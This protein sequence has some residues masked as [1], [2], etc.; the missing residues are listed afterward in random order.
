MAQ[1]P[2]TSGAGFILGPEPAPLERTGRPIC[3]A[4]SD[5]ILEPAPPVC[6]QGPKPEVCRLGPKP[7]VCR[8]GPKPEVCRQGPKPEVCRLGP[9]PEVY[10][11]PERTPGPISCT[12]TGGGGC[13]PVQNLAGYHTKTAFFV[14]I[15]PDSCRVRTIPEVY[16]H[17][18]GEAIQAQNPRRRT[19]F[20]E[21][22]LSL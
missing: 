2:P 8:Q 15:G 22:S 18:A 1:V 21:K 6:R 11:H 12:Y 7:E 10:E 5:N 13:V 4:G 17:P 19:G 3:G 9:K 16:V 20:R 14:G